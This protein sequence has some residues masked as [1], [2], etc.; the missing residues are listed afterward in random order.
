MNQKEVLFLEKEDG[1]QLTLVPDEIK[2]GKQGDSE[3]EKEK[4]DTEKRSSVRREEER[5]AKA[6]D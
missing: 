5:G 2:V 4:E 3:R 6:R 1:A